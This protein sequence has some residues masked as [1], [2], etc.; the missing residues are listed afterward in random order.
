VGNDET[1]LIQL[2]STGD[3]SGL[4][5]QLQSLVDLGYGHVK[6]T[7]VCYDRPDRLRGSKEHRTIH[8]TVEEA[9]DIIKNFTDEKQ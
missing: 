6:S 3:F 9:L 1:F 5:Q 4:T 8:I 7:V 2:Y